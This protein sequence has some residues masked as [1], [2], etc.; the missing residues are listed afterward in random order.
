MASTLNS[1][2]GVVSGS[3]GLKSTADSSGVLALQTNGTTA[4]TVDTSQNVGIGT[5]SPSA[6]LAVT[7]SATI[8]KNGGTGANAGLLLSGGGSSTNFNIDYGTVASNRLYFR[9]N[10]FDGSGNITFQ[11]S[12]DGTMASPIDV[13]AIKWGGG[14][15]VTGLVDISAATSGQIQFPAT[16]NASANANTLD[17]YEEGT[18]TPTQSNFS[19]TGSPTLTGAYTKIGR[20][21]YFNISFAC[22]GT[23]GYSASALISLPFNGI[24]QSGMIAMWVS[25]GG[26]SQTSN[27]S[28]VQMQIDAANT[29]F[30]LGN[31]TTTS[32]GEALFF[33][34][35][36]RVS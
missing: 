25:S 35:F 18:Y 26:V 7:G 14:I 31:F 10:Y 12:S 23:I 16:Q 11:Y 32:A 24:D 5:V 36:Y 17:D 9:Q 21:V 29:R 15:A 30:F 20:V 13:L 33:G 4:V 6:K 22:T 19:I 2:N 1:D 3:A 27:K 8:L 28:G 34:G